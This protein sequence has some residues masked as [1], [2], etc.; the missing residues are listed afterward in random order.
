MLKQNNIVEEIARPDCKMIVIHGYSGV[1]K[2]SLVQA[3]LIPALKHSSI[4]LEEV[5]VISSFAK[6]P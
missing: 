4:G 6:V 5:R 3:G 2:S 1:G